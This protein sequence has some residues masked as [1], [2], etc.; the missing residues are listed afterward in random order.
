MWRNDDSTAPGSC[1]TLFAR[2]ISNAD[3]MTED[4]LIQA[5]L[6][7]L[8]ATALRK[9]LLEASWRDPV[10]HEKLRL[11]AT[12]AGSKGLSVLRKG[13]REATSTNGFVDWRESGNYA[14]RLEDLAELLE[15]RIA[16]GQVELVEVIEEAIALAE[17]AL[18]SVDDSGGVVMPAILGLKKVHLA[19]CNALQP[20]PVALA[21]RLHDF[22]MNGEWDTFH[23]L[24]PDYAGAL[25]EAGLQAYRLR[26]EEAWQALP[27][28]GP[29]DYRGEWS[30]SRFRV[31]SAM[32]AIARHAD[33]FDLL[34]A[35]RAKNLSSPSYFLTLARLFRA[36]GRL[37][38]ALAWAEQG[39]AGFPDQRCDDLLD[40]AVEL[41]L[42][43]GN[44]PEAERLAWL[45]FERSAGCEAFFRLMTVADALDRRAALRA[46]ALDLL[47]RSVAEDES[48][49]RVARRAM[50][51]K[52][53][54]GEIVSIFLR[55]GDADAMWEAF[56][57]GEV[58]VGLWGAVAEARAKSDHEDAIALYKRLLPHVV[59]SG[60]QGSQYALAFTIV[61]KIQALR[62]GHRQT[63]IFRDELGEMR[64]TWKRKR[65]FMKLLDAL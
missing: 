51:E 41:L 8:D 22:Q 52:P 20:D 55:E 36:R 63:G 45:R 17:E 6:D 18:Q 27:Q 54:R 7:A 53:V 24:L 46:R 33:D 25:G 37:D 3:F 15:Q 48:R 30:T 50:W 59:E 60:S 11:A 13:V 32:E 1:G 23:E 12:V 10:L 5:Y 21:G 61:K 43:R 49:E 38:E 44:K 4:E 64:L 16:D 39:I 56:R 65:N 35:V 9:L 40:L 2:L 62:A 28:R 14:R 58:A 31:E 19:A 26:V 42:A 34:V 47:W 57:G 29:A